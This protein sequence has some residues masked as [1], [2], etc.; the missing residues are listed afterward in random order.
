MRFVACLVSLQ[1]QAATAVFTTSVFTVLFTF[2]FIAVFFTS[3]FTSVFIVV[4]IWFF[5]LLGLSPE[6]PEACI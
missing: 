1:H 5:R 2:V 6:T 4:F 3:V